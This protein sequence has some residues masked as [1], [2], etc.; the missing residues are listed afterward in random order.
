VTRAGQA[1]LTVVVPD[2]GPVSLRIRWSRF[3]QVKGPGGIDTGL[4][5][6]GQG[7]TRLVAPRAGTYVVSG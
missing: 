6:D 1:G 5:P 2:A 3:L 4:R 7:W